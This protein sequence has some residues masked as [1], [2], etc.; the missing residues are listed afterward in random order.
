MAQFFKITIICHQDTKK[1]ENL[2]NAETERR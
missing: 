2:F 1:V